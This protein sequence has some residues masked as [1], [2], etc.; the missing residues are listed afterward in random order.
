MFPGREPPEAGG[1]LF[2]GGTDHS[3]I[4]LRPSQQAEGNSCMVQ[5]FG[6]PSYGTFHTACCDLFWRK[7]EEERVGGIRWHLGQDEWSCFG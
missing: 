5:Q 1:G 6:K 7:T 3:G 4:P 2:A